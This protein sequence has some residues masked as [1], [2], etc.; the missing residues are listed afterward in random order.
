MCPVVLLQKQSSNGTVAGLTRPGLADLE[1][2]LGI[3]LESPFFLTKMLLCLGD[4]IYIRK[5]LKD[6]STICS[7]TLCNSCVFSWAVWVVV[8]MLWKFE[9]TLWNWPLSLE[10]RTHMQPWRDHIPTTLTETN[11]PPPQKHDHLRWGRIK[12]FQLAHFYLWQSCF[13]KA[14]WYFSGDDSQKCHHNQGREDISINEDHNE[15]I[16]QVHRIYWVLGPACVL[17]SFQSLGYFT[18]WMQPTWMIKS[19]WK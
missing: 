10:I 3:P 11:L 1:V 6:S 13:Q 8:N 16:L 14:A 18:I 7:S 9:V 5:P 19:P 2:F 15:E 12:S 17:E 4:S